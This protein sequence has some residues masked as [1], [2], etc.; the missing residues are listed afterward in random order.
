MERSEVSLAPHDPPDERETIRRLRHLADVVERAEHVPA[1]TDTTPV[2]EPTRI[3]GFSMARYVQTTGTVLDTECSTVCCLGG[4]ACSIWGDPC[5]PHIWNGSRA[6]EALGLKSHRLG[7]VLFVPRC[8]RAD[9]P[10]FLLANISPA[11]AARACR[12]LAT[13]SRTSP[14]ASS[15]WGARTGTA[16]SRGSPR[17]CGATR[18]TGA[19]RGPVR[20]PGGARLP[21]R[22]AGRPAVR[23][24]PEPDRKLTPPAWTAE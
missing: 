14:R 6:S 21:R 5:R 16:S 15:P 12:R 22:L 3:D 2:S 11:R 19:V 20:R 24:A 10:E 4:Y 1:I 13:C 17:R 23:P 18:R 7:D 9:D 8:L